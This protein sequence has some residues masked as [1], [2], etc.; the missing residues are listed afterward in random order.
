MKRAVVCLSGG[1]DSTTVLAMAKR[2]YKCLAIT[3][4]YGQ[5]H[6]IE[7]KSAARV[8]HKMQV[9][10]HRVVIATGT[11]GDSSLID[12]EVR[13]PKDRK[14][15][16][17]A[18]HV[19]SGEVPSTYVP[20]RNT[21]FLSYA[22]AF[23]E[24]MKAHDIFIGANELDYS[25]YPDCRPAFIEAFEALANLATATTERIQIHA[26]LMQMDKAAIIKAGSALNVDYALTHSCYDPQ[27]DKACGRCDSCVLRR[28]GFLE[29]G[30]PDPTL[31]V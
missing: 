18:K 23:A 1:L 28:Q 8:A 13:V 3:F 27:N 6:S 22:L 4:D 10:L 5:R 16:D 14:V 15:A 26:P 30:V 7:L 9:P 20:A 21:L 19:E 2:D 31:Y 11:F 29:A 25:G 12:D 17:I 24:S